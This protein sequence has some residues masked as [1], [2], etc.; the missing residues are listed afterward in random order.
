MTTAEAN[1]RLIEGAYS[2]FARGDL[3]AVFQVLD[4]KIF[5]HIPGRGPLTGDYRGHQELLGFFQRFMQHSGGTFRVRVDDIDPLKRNDAIVSGDR[6]E[7]R[8]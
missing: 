5:W 2:A 7:R 8:L 1:R 6:R 3:A 4:E